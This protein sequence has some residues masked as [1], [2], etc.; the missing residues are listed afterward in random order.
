M[1]R[2]VMSLA[3]LLMGSACSPPSVPSPA[4][5]AIP[6]DGLMPMPSRAL[7]KCLS[8]PQLRPACPTRVPVIDAPSR[9]RA[10]VFKQERAL[11]A[12][13]IEW[14]APYPRL[15]SK[16]APPRFA[17]LAVYGGD[18]TQSMADYVVKE[19]WEGQIPANRSFGLDFGEPTWNGRRGEL[20]LA[21]PYPLGG[22][23]GDHLVFRW[24]DDET[25]YKVSLHAWEPIEETRATLEAIMGSL[26]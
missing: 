1:N 5:T 11:Q 7:L 4:P 12:F 25:S 16:N 20:I 3:V 23:D 24:T 14:N 13:S 22:M 10:L 15:T 21:P 9:P 6:L 18:L 19:E 8:H 17:H 26:P 2:L